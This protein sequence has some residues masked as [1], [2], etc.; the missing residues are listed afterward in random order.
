MDLYLCFICFLVSSF[1]L[2]A[3]FLLTCAV[4]RGGMN[5]MMT[6]PS[7]RQMRGSLVR[8]K[9][10]KPS[11]DQRFIE[12]IDCCC[13]GTE[14]TQTDAGQNL[15]F[16]PPVLACRD[17]ILQHPRTTSCD[18]LAQIPSSMPLHSGIYAETLISNQTSWL[19]FSNNTFL[20]TLEETIGTRVVIPIPGG[21]IELL[22]TKQVFEDQHVIDFVTA[23]YNLSLEEEALTSITAE[24][25][26]QEMEA[27]QM[28][29]TSERQR[30]MDMQQY[31]EAL[32]P[33]I[34][35]QEGNEKRDS[36]THEAEGQAGDFMSDCSD[37][38]D[39]EADTKYQRRTGKRP[40]A[41][42]LIAERKRRKKLNDRLYAL[43]SLVPIIS[44]LD[45]ASI[46][47]DAIEYVKQ[48]QKQAKQ[49]QDELD[50][51]AEDDAAKNNVKSEIQSRSGVDHIRPKSDD[52]Q[53]DHKASNGFHFGTPGD[54]SISKQSRD[55]SYAVHDH[56]TEQMEPQV[57]VAQLDGNQF[58]VKVFC[59]QKPGG[60][61]RLM[62]AL[63][64]LCLEVTNANVTTFRCLV[65]NVFIV[66]K[67]DTDMVEADD[68]R[69]SLLE[70]IRNPLRPRNETAKTE[71]N[72]VGLDNHHDHHHHQ[73]L[74]NHHFSPLHLH[75]LP[76]EA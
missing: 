42:N 39:E 8:L 57:E 23:Q 61:E 7:L 32:V 20:S 18:L 38:I 16:P 62:E 65:S 53:D 69:D 37:Q 70:L 58:F 13:A 10:W 11:E 72:G 67:K 27:M 43:R 26:F 31:M 33:N 12:L 49:L 55:Y 47:G 73:H 36:N 34:D 64:S 74:H 5:M 71:E 48:L 29:I 2:V 51:H 3:F 54:C 66:E 59:E 14:I 35:Q 1:A 17:T 50:D 25:G 68:V 9:S 56:K 22:V 45:R 24:N 60:F 28:S 41:K 63:S 76:N 4:K 46:L 21:I 75:H 44:K 52:H 15:P 40:Q 30:H 19:N 6:L